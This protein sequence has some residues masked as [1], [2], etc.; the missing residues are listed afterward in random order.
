MLTMFG[1]HRV[2]G[3][4]VF[5]AA[6]FVLGDGAVRLAPA[7]SEVATWWPAAGLSVGV[8]AAFYR[9]RWTLAVA[10]ALSSG[11]ANMAGGRP[12]ATAVGFGLANTAEALVA[13]CWLRRLANGRP[14]LHGLVDVWRLCIAA[15][16]GAVTA[17][18]VAAA[19]VDLSAD[20]SVTQAFARVVPSHLAAVLLIVPLVLSA[21]PVA[22]RGAFEVAGTWA[23]MVVVALL[24]FAPGQALPLAFVV[25]SPLMLAAVRLGVRTVASQLIALGVLVTWLTGRGAG[26]FAE[27][28]TVSWSSSVQVQ[29]FIVVSAL[30]VLPLAVA[31][32]ERER[33]VARAEASEQL[34][35]RGF[36]DSLVGMLLVRV[37]QA[38]TL[39]VVEANPVAQAKLGVGHGDQVPAALRDD[40][41]R[42][43]GDIAS[44]SLAGGGWRGEMNHG[45]DPSEMQ[46]YSVALSPLSGPTSATL[47]TCQIID[48]TARYHAERELERQAL[49]DHLTGLANRMMFDQRL[50]R[51]L[52]SAA[53][54]GDRVTVMF[55]DLDDFK[56]INDGFGHRIGDDLLTDF[57][58]RL[59]SLIRPGDMVARMGGDEFA[60][61]CPAVATPDVARE[62][63]ERLRGAADESFVIGGVS[64][65]VGVSIGVTISSAG[66]TTEQLLAEADLA[67]YGAKDAGKHAVELYSARLGDQAA[68]RV[69]LEADLQ[70]AFE[71]RE[72]EMYMQPVMTIG[73]GEI[74]AAEALIRWNHPERGLV[75]PDTWLGAAEGS[76]LMSKLGTWVLDESC[77]QGAT[78]PTPVG[79][80]HAP[81]VHVNVSTRQLD[82]PGFADLV[83]E[84][85]D[86][87]DLSPTRLVIE[88]T[89]TYL[90][91]IADYLL[92]ELQTLSD[93][94]VRLAADDFGTGYSPLTRITELPVKMLKI[95]K[96][97]IEAVT[98]DP[99]SLAIV[100]SLVEL[101]NTLE[102]DVVAE[103]I[104]YAAQADL[105]HAL[106]CPTAQGHLWHPA[107]PA[108][109]FLALLTTPHGAPAY[110]HQPT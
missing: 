44:A 102:L 79:H 37:D 10:I 36:Q 34:F 105:V 83:I 54:T 99:R 6:V 32:S 84:T 88:L 11:L 74:E 13:A 48:A 57:A 23:L 28:A 50:Q 76:G 39:Y 91:Q 80:A 87:H 42:S 60:V 21:S 73:T 65:H 106:G 78:W 75:P 8:V 71:R 108:A 41:G 93:L 62:L 56:L 47:A 40:D 66:S 104:E 25:M 4:L 69:R 86:R 2:I 1:T 29:I 43:L 17:G 110:Q 38:P 3:M 98:T 90:A 61:L 27:A 107:L 18:V 35:R 46:R 12:L 15:A 81:T 89:E 45:S 68:D 53:E 103:G 67:L 109:E 5:C 59:S 22:R 31:M 70:S 49:R 51:E 94:G 30:I 55:M 26:P 82:T 100:S 72:F 77:R 9:S 92:L 33:A 52:D 14:A 24:V 96:Q 97:F 20:G 64:F 85:L 7:G 19:T 95:D 63:A 101:A 58:Q 16:V